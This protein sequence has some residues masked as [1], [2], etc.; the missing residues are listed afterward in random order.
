MPTNRKIPSSTILSK[1]CSSRNFA[2]ASRISS[3]ETP[4]ARVSLSKNSSH[5]AR[6]SV[7][8]SSSQCS[9]TVLRFAAAV[10]SC[11]TTTSSVRVTSG[12]PKRH[13]GKQLFR[14]H[15]GADHGGDRCGDWGCVR[16]LTHNGEFEGCY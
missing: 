1:S 3:L 13:C 8:V 4:L 16:H 10:A 15:A 14:R 11:S 5:F 12:E 2:H 6:L 7:M 9:R